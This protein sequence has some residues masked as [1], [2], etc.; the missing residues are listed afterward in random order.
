MTC[1]V[2]VLNRLGLALAADSAVTFSSQALS[3]GTTTYSSGANKIFQLTESEPVGLM[4]FNSAVLQGVPWELI[5]KSFRKQFGSKSCSKLAD[6]RQEL[7]GFIAQHVELFPSSHKDAE[8]QSLCAQAALVLIEHV[9]QQCPSLFDIANVAT[10][11]TDWDNVINDVKQTL[12]SKALPSFFTINDVA[13]TQT[14]NCAWLSAEIDNFLSAD[15]KTAHLA[16]YFSNPQI[17]NLS[18]EGLY[19]FYESVFRSNYTG[20]VLAGYGKDEFF[21]SYCE[22]NYFGFVGAQLVWSDIAT[23]SIDHSKSSAIEAFARKSM[24]ETFLVGAAPSIWGHARISFAR[25]AKKACSDVLTKINGTI[26]PSDLETIVNAAQTA[27][28]GEWRANVSE[29]HY[30]PLLQVVSSLTPEELSELAETLVM[31]ESLKEK[32]TSRTQSVGGPVDVAVIT[33]AEGL[34]WIKR[35]LFFSPELNHRYF[36]RQR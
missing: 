28:E 5:V 1:E 17:A 29:T 32:V 20:V 27:F 25:F 30:D 18:I 22:L 16:Q 19:K 23:G 3:H 26:Q 31:L 11:P 33:K 34:V 15:P 24:V 36:L 4:V 10:H 13:D 2:A 7:A 12:A 6:Y 21:P 8:L 9:R 14:K 35:K